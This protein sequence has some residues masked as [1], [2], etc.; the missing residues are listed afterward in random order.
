M[1]MLLWGHRYAHMVAGTTHSS[2]QPQILEQPFS[3]PVRSPKCPNY[4][5]YNFEYR[6]KID[7]STVL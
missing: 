3:E 4:V 6:K 2:P 1:G 5:N 7:P